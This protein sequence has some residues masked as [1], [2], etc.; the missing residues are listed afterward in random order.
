MG[1]E[2][3]P[4][5]TR[6]LQSPQINSN[7]VGFRPRMASTLMLTSRENLPCRHI[8]NFSILHRDFHYSRPSE[9]NTPFSSENEF[10]D[11]ADAFLEDL[12][13][14]VEVLEDHL[15]DFDAE[16]SQG[17]LNVSLGEHGNYVLNKQR[18]NMQIWW[19]SPVSGPKRFEFD[20]QAWMSTRGGENLIDLL[21]EE[22]SIFFPLIKF[23]GDS[24]TGLAIK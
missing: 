18:P 6:V 11:E 14:D 4:Q 16:Y 12:L 5:V 22:L 8:L 1:L 17:V 15:E 23:E 24:N 21:R 9:S 7:I 3:M 20:G 10:N 19:S 13:S 2:D